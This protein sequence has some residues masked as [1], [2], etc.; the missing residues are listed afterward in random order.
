MRGVLSS[1]LENT[2]A[3]AT[4][5][6]IYEEHL[7]ADEKRLLLLLAA[8]GGRLADNEMKSLDASLRLSAAELR[9]RGYTRY[10]AG[11]DCRLR[12]AFLGHWFREWPRYDWSFSA[13]M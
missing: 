4:I 11:G 7:S 8:H 13:R 12:V 2:N 5:A 3:A 1:A 6:N 10:E 9:Q